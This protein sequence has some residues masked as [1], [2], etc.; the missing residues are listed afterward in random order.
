[1]MNKSPKVAMNNERGVMTITATTSGICRR[2]QE[3][4]LV[5]W[6]PA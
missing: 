4:K 1:M 5:R 2:S 3:A 6:L